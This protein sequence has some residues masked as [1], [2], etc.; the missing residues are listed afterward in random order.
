MDPAKAERLALDLMRQ[1]N[2]RGLFRKFTGTEW[3]FRWSRAKK[4][5][6]TCSS[7]KRT[8]TL[9]RPLTELNGEVDVRDCILHE[10]AHALAGH[11]NGHNEVWKQHCQLVGARPNRCY[12]STRIAAPPAKWEAACPGCEKIYKKYRKPKRE[13]FCRSCLKIY[14]PEKRPAL[15]LKWTRRES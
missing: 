11:Q 6:G 13:H 12:D 4:T 3:K 9:S 10:I 8:I 2:L 1:W 15:V 5:F 14:A 7:W